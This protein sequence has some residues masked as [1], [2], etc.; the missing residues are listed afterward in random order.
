MVKSS[1]NLRFRNSRRKML[2]SKAVVRNYLSVN[3]TC[4]LPIDPRVSVL[5]GANDHGKSNLLRSLEHLNLDRPITSELQN[6]DAKGPRIDYL[7]TLANEEVDE[8]EAIVKASQDR[9]LQETE[10][11]YLENQAL[12]ALAREEEQEAARAAEAEVRE[13]ERLEAEKQAAANV[14]STALTNPVSAAA[15][16]VNSIVA[17]AVSAAT[18]VQ[19]PTPNS[20][21]SS[22]VVPTPLAQSS[23]TSSLLAID[24]D[25]APASDADWEEGASFLTAREAKEIYKACNAFAKSL[26]AGP[27]MLT[28]DGVDAPLTVHGIAI[29]DMPDAVTAFLKKNIPRVELFRSFSGELQDSVTAEQ[30]ATPEAEFLQG[31]FFYA[32]IDPLNCQDLFEQTDET[33]K[34]LEDASQQLDRELRGL[35][36]QGV[37]LNLHFQ[38]RHFGNSIELLAKDPAVKKRHARMSKRSA[39]VTQFFRLSMVLHARRQ[40]NPANSYIYVFDEP[41]VFL[42]PKGQKD[43]LAVFEQLAEDTQIVYATHSL[44]MLNQNYPER[45]RLITRNDSTTIVDSKPYK[46]NWRMAVDALGVRL[47]SNILF[48]PNILLV[49][50]DS[51]PLYI[52]ELFRALNRLGRIDADANLL[53]VVSYSDL[54]NLRFLL[55]MFRSESNERLV[56]VLFDGDNAGKTYQKQV[57]ALCKK[58][59]VEALSL[60]AGSAIEDYC[61]YPDLFLKAVEETLKMSYEATGKAIPTDLPKQVKDSLESFMEKKARFA[62][63]GQKAR[64]QA[65]DQADDAQANGKI[66]DPADLNTGRWFKDWTESILEGGSSK[67]ALARNYAQLARD[68]DPGTGL[69]DKRAQKAE[70]LLHAVAT[71]LKLPSLKA[72]KAIEEA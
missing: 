28:R 38:L 2:L 12:L 59:S 72:K 44:F 13:A 3:G 70:A 62:S 31:I 14:S 47:T 61:L 1:L 16:Q 39:G 48:S 21:T 64:K 50:G 69:D 22:A 6:W 8:I 65:E 32:G 10:R 71:N 60:D 30:I 29:D 58:L 18:S 24:D 34:H 15:P 40:K 51:D 25:D 17:A 37:D 56:T 19:N 63:A 66:E 55:Q 52:F 67:V 35:W 27:L 68:R 5:L 7:F 23:T 11:E 45:H 54:P 4:E 46:A 20:I 33:D 53:G 42:H 57:S 9:Y 36:A 43:L 49:E 26:S 41:G